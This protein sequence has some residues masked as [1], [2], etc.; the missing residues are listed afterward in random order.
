[1][2]LG[3]RRAWSTTSRSSARTPGT[4]WAWSCCAMCPGLPA[5]GAPY[6][7]WS[8]P[9]AT[10]SPSDSR[11]TLPAWSQRRSGGSVRSIPLDGRAPGPRR[12]ATLRLVSLEDE[13]RAAFGIGDVELER[14]PTPVNDVVVVR[15][16]NEV[17]ALKL[18]HRKR[19]MEQVRWEAELVR[20]LRRLGAPVV[21]P[22]EGRRGAV[23]VL[24]VDG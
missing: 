13:V 1:M 17:F 9:A 18:Y 2:N 15:T 14:L 8:C 16:P 20:H 21:A 19:T 24:T 23:E 4:R 10:T 22:V 5:L 11:W 12:V 6:R 7:S 3:G